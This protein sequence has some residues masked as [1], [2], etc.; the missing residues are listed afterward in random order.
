LVDSF[1]RL[2]G[3]GE[4]GVSQDHTLRVAPTGHVLGG[5]CALA[6]SP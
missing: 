6:A 5:R 2:V 3:D 1:C 4:I